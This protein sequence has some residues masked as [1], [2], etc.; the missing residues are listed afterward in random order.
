MSRVHRKAFLGLALV[1]AAASSILVRECRSERLPMVPVYWRASDLVPPGDLSPDDLFQVNVNGLTGYI[2][3]TGSMR[4]TPRFEH[5]SPFSEGLAWASRDG[6]YGY[7]DTKGEWVIQPSYTL[8]QHFSHGLAP[9]RNAGGLHGYIRP[10]GSWAIE[11][12][13]ESARSFNT[14]GGLSSERSRSRADFSRSS[15]QNRQATGPIGGSTPL[16]ERSRHASIHTIRQSNPAASVSNGKEVASAMWITQDNSS[17]NPCSQRPASSQRVWR[18]SEP[19]A[20]S[21]V[22]S[23]PPGTGSSNRNGTG[24]TASKTACAK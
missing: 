7:I 5:A 14:D 20:A 4:I 22:A 21:G 10:D 6:L 1:S 2:D 24:H 17:F 23:M 9:V 18:P 19:S 11:P 3:R 12:Q 15:M 16:V 8:A 13:F